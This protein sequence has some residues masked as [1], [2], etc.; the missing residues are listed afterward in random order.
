MT[1][2]QETQCQLKRRPI[3]LVK[4]AEHRELSSFFHWYGS[5][6]GQEVEQVTEGEGTM[7]GTFWDSD[8]FSSSSCVS[9]ADFLAESKIRIITVILMTTLQIWRSSPALRELY[10]NVGTVT[11]KT[12]SKH[13]YVFT[14]SRCRTQHRH[15]YSGESSAGVRE[16][17]V[18]P[19]RSEDGLSCGLC[20]HILGL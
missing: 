6:K 2:K 4:Q 18:C 11:K 20:P 13:E 16:H 3:T 9:R 7:K 10:E 1:P 12:L 5:G 14:L 8:L 15:L 17:W 19:G